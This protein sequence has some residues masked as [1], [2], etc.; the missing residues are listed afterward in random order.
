MRVTKKR[1]IIVAVAIII[2]IIILW[3]AF[4]SGEKIP[5]DPA[6]ASIIDSNGFGNLTTSGD[7]SVSWTRAIKILRSGEV[8]SV[9]QSHK[10]KVVLIMKNGDKITT[11]EPSIDEIITQIELCKNTCSQI[12]IATE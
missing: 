8:D 4:G 9:S 3:F 6:S 10:L 11:T 12:L 2:L 7:A 1:L 5:A